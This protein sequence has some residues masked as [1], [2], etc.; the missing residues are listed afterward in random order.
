MIDESQ[1]AML[2]SMREALRE[3][4]ENFRTPKR[5]D[6]PRDDKAK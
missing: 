6:K 1:R 3:S 2:L 5:D 4:L